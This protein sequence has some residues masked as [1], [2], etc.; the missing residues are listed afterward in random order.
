MGQ[1][2]EELKRRNVLRVAAAY[3]VVS[4]LIIQVVETVFPAFG[5]G[6]AAVRFVTIVLAIGL[7][8][9]L[10]LSWAFEITPEGLKKDKDV[11]RSQPIV[12]HAGKKLDRIIMVV[13][14]LA[15]GYFAIDKFVLSESR[16][17][18][19]AEE[20]RQEGRS[21]ALVESYGDK[22]IAV[23]PF[24]DMSP[25]KDQ[26]YFGDG[27]AEAIINRL[28]S[29]EAL[30]VTSRTSAFAFKES[31]LSIPE[32][33]NKLGARYVVEGS[34]RSAGNQLRITAQLIEVDSDSHLWSE[35]Y[36]R[37]LDDIFA[38]QDDI[39]R[40]ITDSLEVRLV[41]ADA[42]EQPT[43]NLEAYRLYLQGHHLL[44]QRGIDNLVAAIGR[45][46][47]AVALDQEFAEAWADL[48]ISIV[49][50]PVYDNQYDREPTLVAA[51]EAADRA[52]TLDPEL[53]QGWAA[54]GYI[55]VESFKWAE[56]SAAFE[57]V[58]ELNPN[59]DTGWLWLSVGYQYT[60][61]PADALPMVERAVAIAPQS[62]INNG[63]L[64]RTHLMSG[65]LN[66]ARQAIEEAIAL[67]WPIAHHDMAA[68]ATIEGESDR[69]AEGVR[70]FISA[71]GDV[72][73][74][75]LSIYAN[76]FVDPTA[77]EAALPLLK[78]DIEQ[79]HYFQSLWG[80]LLLSEGES[81]VYVL[82]ALSNSPNWV[83]STLWYPPF[84][85]MLKQQVVKDHLY[86]IGLVD[87]W[88]DVGWPDFCRPL[89]DDDF[90]CD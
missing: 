26:E 57:R 56:A 30:E 33:A 84:R 23:L 7:I 62:G 85:S 63:V 50:L 90:E 77:R 55:F 48:A 10:I 74:D 71:M 18:N 53:A 28:V 80:S 19:I 66:V 3:V 81:L 51:G 16:E 88:G 67:G 54:R 32:I 6:D 5:F 1:F 59:N 83:R 61:Y 24:V 37:R 35:T 89:G 29:I 17:A 72:H 31:N 9:T 70:R 38:I 47:K 58:V 86:R 87:F 4:W 8:P 36:D 14:A 15:I 21:E 13:M 11:D 64:G 41:D 49:L 73:D 60:G 76:A 34:V 75:R 43:E 69:I 22:S 25:N 46:K 44:M 42:P 65:N 40:S 39:S 12:A 82:E 78:A 2:F 68:L 79:G 45:F 20:A 52:L 27:I